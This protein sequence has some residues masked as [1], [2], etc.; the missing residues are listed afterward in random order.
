M[1]GNNF[2]FSKC[3]EKV[4]INEHSEEPILITLTDTIINIESY[5]EISVIEKVYLRNNQNS[6]EKNTLL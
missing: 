3:D 6:S 5:D 2:C 4:T 1:G